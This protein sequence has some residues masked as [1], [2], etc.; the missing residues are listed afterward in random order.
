MANNAGYDGLMFFGSGQPLTVILKAKVADDIGKKL[1]EADWLDEGL[2]E[3]R[4]TVAGLVYAMT[5]TGPGAKGE[6]ALAQLGEQ[7]NLKVVKFYGALPNE[8]TEKIRDAVD[9]GQILPTLVD[10]LLKPQN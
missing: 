4:S 7:L 1:I 5:Y 9:A 2:W 6:T 10:E 8:A 3:L